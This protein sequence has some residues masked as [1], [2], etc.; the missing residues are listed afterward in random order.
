MAPPTMPGQR[1]PP[2]EGPIDVAEAPVREAGDAGREDLGRMDAGARGRRRDAEAEHHRGRREA[3]GHADRAIDEL[4]RE[5][6]RD[7]QDEIPDHR[8]SG[9]NP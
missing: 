2:D 3:V 8:S 9:K 7:E 1:Q 5:A 4:R 6:D